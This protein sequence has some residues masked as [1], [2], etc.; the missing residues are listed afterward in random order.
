VAYSGLAPED[1]AAIADQL[2]KDGVAYEIGGGGAT[3]SVPANKV[4]ETRIKLAQAGLPK[5]GSIGLEIFDK[6]NF[7]ATDFVQQVNFRRGLEGELADRSTRSMASERAASHRDAEG[8][9]FKEDRQN[10]PPCPPSSN[11][12]PASVRTRCAALRTRFEL[13]RGLR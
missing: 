6:T 7:G 13:G 3:V 4:A 1:S 10:R 8:G 9:V 2:E 11:P 12:E 5:G